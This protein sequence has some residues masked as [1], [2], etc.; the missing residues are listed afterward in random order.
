MHWYRARRVYDWLCLLI[1]ADVV[2]ISRKPTN[3]V[4]AKAAGKDAIDAVEVAK[5]VLELIP[6]RIAQEKDA[7]IKADLQ[8]QVEEA[9]QTLATGRS[10]ALDSFRLAMKFRRPRL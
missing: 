5:R 9:K 7:K 4:E 6:A 1:K 3:F 2:L 8:K 10:K